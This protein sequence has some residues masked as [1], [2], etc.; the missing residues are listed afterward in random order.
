M[1]GPV[2][3]MAGA[4]F[5]RRAGTLLAVFSDRRVNLGKALS[6]LALRFP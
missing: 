1:E 4:F 6:Q 5:A 2:Q 3:K